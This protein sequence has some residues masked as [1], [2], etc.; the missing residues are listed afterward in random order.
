[1]S[2]TTPS[3]EIE[4]FETATKRIQ[5]MRRA[6]DRGEVSEEEVTDEVDKFLEKFGFEALKALNKK[7]KK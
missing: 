2:E 6:L 7:D 5:E 4:T 3:T 1:M